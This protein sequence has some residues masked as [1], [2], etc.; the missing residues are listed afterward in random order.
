[1]SVDISQAGLQVY[2]RHPPSPR[3]QP[4]VLVTAAVCAGIAADRQFDLPVGV[5]WGATVIAW[6]GWLILWRGRFD[7]TAGIVLLASAS[8]CA[9]AWHHCR[10]SLYRRDDLAFFGQPLRQPVCVQAIARTSPRRQPE[11]P[12]NPMRLIAGGPISQVELELTAI[13]DRADWRP[14]SGRAS[15][16]VDG[17]LPGVHAGHRLQVFAQLTTPLGARNPGEFDYRQHV[18]ADRMAG[19]LRSEYPQCVTV[20]GQAGW[21]HFGRW[22]DAARAFGQRLLREALDCQQAGLAAAVLLGAREEVPSEQTEAFVQTGTIHILSISGLHVGILAATVFALAQLLSVRRTLVAAVVAGTIV[23]YVLLTDARPPAVRAMIVVLVLCAGYAMGRRPLGFN[24]LAA[25]ALV[26]LAIN[27]ADLFRVGVQLS[28]LC[29]SVLVWFGGRA[30]FPEEAPQ[31]LERLVAQSRAWPLRMTVQG[32]A[33]ARDLAWVGAL[34]W[35]ATLPLVAAR[36]HVLSLVGL[37]LNTLLWLPATLIVWSGLALLVVGGLVPILAWPVGWCCQ[38]VLGLLWWAIERARELPGAYFWV[39]GPPEWWLAGYY[40]GL[41][42]LA[43][44]PRLRPPRRWLLALAAGWLT[45]GMA[46]ALVRSGPLRF[47]ATFLAVDHGCAV[48]LRLPSG[49]T[50]L[51]DAGCFKSPESGTHLIARY[52]WSEGI[53]HLDAIVLSHADADHY[54]AVPGLLEQFSVGAAYVSPVMFSRQEE[55]PGALEALRTAFQQAGVPIRQIYAADRLRGGDGC[56]IQVLHPPRDGVL[57]GS[58][59]ANSIVL[60]IEYLGRRLLLAGDLEPPGLQYVLAEE[61]WPCDVLLAPHHGGRR[62]NLPEL[63]AWARPKWVLISG[64]PYE[65]VLDTLATYQAIGAQVLH[66]ATHGAIDVQIDQ[67]GLRVETFR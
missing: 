50:V 1:M 48:V 6:A 39:P 62:S 4:L 28:F 38:W 22:I 27:P 33:W 30:P 67:A 24:S 31:R 17:D 8:A 11:P 59:N 53:T 54:N 55:P 45:A 14:A 19:L 23:F 34:V 61:P 41:G 5:W 35:L 49:A 21:W 15:L 51:Y 46:P 42:V 9:A 7:R 43:V 64:G 25:A 12:P 10:W 52:L 58:D 32:L 26:V 63:A 37:V 29:V 20:V 16:V 13:R 40:A 18:R 2:K 60:A 3:Y 44:C 36:F 57:A 65:D 56:W 66:T 47:N